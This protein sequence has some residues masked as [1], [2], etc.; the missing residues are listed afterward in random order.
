MVAE[1]SVENLARSLEFYVEVLGFKIKYERTDECFAFLTYNQSNNDK[2]EVMLDQINVGRSIIVG[3]MNFPLGRGINF[4]YDTNEL[5][6]LIARLASANHPLT[7]PMEEKIYRTNSGDVRQR[8]I[9]LQD[10]D[11]YLLRFVE[12]LP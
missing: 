10:P 12:V 6:A 5:D 1:L 11:G 7:L 3:E 2:S 8:Q 9:W 4:E